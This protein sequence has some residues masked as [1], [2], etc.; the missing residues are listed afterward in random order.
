MAAG[1]LS[2]PHVSSRR[3]GA[4]YRCTL[5]STGRCALAASNGCY[6]AA[7]PRVTACLGRTAVAACLAIAVL[8]ACPFVLAAP[9]TA[10]PPVKCVTNKQSIRPAILVVF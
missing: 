1:R 5:H 7:S 2:F 4:L 9:R 3:T 10:G 8:D 6:P